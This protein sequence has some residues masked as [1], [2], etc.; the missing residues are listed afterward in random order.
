[1][2]GLNAHTCQSH[3]KTTTTT[4]TRR[5][6][7]SR[8]TSAQSVATWAAAQPVP[9]IVGSD[10]CARDGDTPPLGTRPEQLLQAPGPQLVAVTVGGVAAW[11]PSLVMAPVAAHDGLDWATVHQTFL[12]RFEEEEAREEDG[13][14]KL[15]QNLTL[16]EYTL[17]QEAG[18]LRT[19][20]DAARLNRLR[21]YA[22]TGCTSQDG[23]PRA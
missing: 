11:T 18:R 13:V 17:M 3:G 7:F 4:T 22:V 1:M 19:L 16:N 21:M 23:A 20:G 10:A 9:A 15:E 5:L 8:V 2:S 12:A 14:K 6:F